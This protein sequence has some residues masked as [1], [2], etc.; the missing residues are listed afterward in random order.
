[1]TGSADLLLRPHEPALVVL[2][3]QARRLRLPLTETVDLQHQRGASG[4][5]L[6]PPSLSVMEGCGE[7]RCACPH[8]NSTGIGEPEDS[9]ACSA[10]QGGC[11]G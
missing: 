2:L 6:G 8:A 5:L 9:Y 3:L 10:K 1:M 7:A 11:A 4:A